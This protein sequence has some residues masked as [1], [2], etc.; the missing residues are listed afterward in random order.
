MPSVTPCESSEERG[1]S[2]DRKRIGERER[3]GE[4]FIEEMKGG[5]E[6]EVGSQGLSFGFGG[7]NEPL[8]PFFLDDW[9]DCQFETRDSRDIS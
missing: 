2:L 8:R 1:S 4:R 7:R 6:Q 3:E 5:R 9:K